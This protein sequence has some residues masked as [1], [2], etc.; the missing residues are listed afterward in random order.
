MLGFGIAVSDSLRTGPG[1][2]A[3]EDTE[4]MQKLEVHDISRED[5]I[6]GSQEEGK[7]SFVDGGE[8]SSTETI[9]NQNEIDTKSEETKKPITILPAGEPEAQ[10]PQ[11][12]SHRNRR[13]RGTKYSE[14]TI[15]PQ[16]GDKETKETPKNLPAGEPE[17]QQ[18][19]VQTVSTT[20][21][22]LSEEPAAMKPET[23]V[24]IPT[25]DTT[26]TTVQSTKETT[27]STADSTTTLASSVPDTDYDGNGDVES[28]TATS[29]EV[30]GL[31]DIDETSMVSGDTETEENTSLTVASEQSRTNQNANFT[32]PDLVDGDETQSSVEQ[33]QEV[34]NNSVA[35]TN[36]KSSNVVNEAA[37]TEESSVSEDTTGSPNITEESEVD[38]VAEPSASDYPDG[39]SRSHVLACIGIVVCLFGFGANV[40]L[41]FAIK[42]VGFC[43]FST[44]NTP[45]IKKLSVGCS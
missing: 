5:E 16:P 37:V 41:M 12:I 32:K 6:S 20:T 18:P 19:G 24:A 43:C 8:L 38:A 29:A 30:T 35:E 36:E 22:E 34:I 4:S 11:A 27:M 7:F 13:K 17:E 39:D 42:K 3:V 45:I 40:S 2:S 21:G 44:D 28:Y 9:R 31:T 15:D 25:T 26:S 10:L 1:D 33:E 14:V 23:S